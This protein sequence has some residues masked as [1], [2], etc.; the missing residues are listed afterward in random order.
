[1]AEFHI[2][3]KIRH[4]YQL[5]DA[6]FQT[7]GNILLANFRVSR[8][9]AQN[10]NTQND[11][12]FPKDGVR[13]GD[14]HAMGLIDEIFHFV[15]TLYK[16][17][18]NPDFFRELLDQLDTN[19]TQKTVD[20]L[21]TTFIAEF[22][23]SSV[24]RDQMTAQDYL[25]ASENGIPNREIALEELML[26]WLAN[27][28]PAYQPL[29][30]LF[31]DQELQKLPGYNLVTHYLE[32]YS[33]KQPRFGPRNTDLVY[34]LRSPALMVP[35]SIHG[36]LEYIRT[37]W[38]YLLSDFLLRILSS[39]DFL[40]EEEKLSFMGPGPV[41]IPLYDQSQAGL[42]EGE[43]YSRD[44]DWMPNLVLIAKNSFVWLHQ[45]AIKYKKPVRF[46][47][48]IPDEE[49]Q[50][51][52]QRGINGLWLIGLWERSRASA[53][54]KQ[55]CGNPEAISSAYALHDY[56]IAGDL[57]GEQA[58]EDLDRR[59]RRFGI[60]LASDMVP[61]HM[62][63]DSNWVMDHPDWFI[64]LPY[65]PFP[66]YRFSGP[67]LSDRADVGIFIDD[68][69]YDHSDAAVVF[70]RVDRRSGAEQYI[71]H[72]N[73]GTSFPWNDTAQLDYL[74][75]E[76]REAVIQTIIQVAKRFHI[77]RFDAAMTLT[78]KHFHRLW[79]PQPGSGGDIPSRAE[80][81][82]TDE[83]FSHIMPNEFWREVVDR[84]AV[85]APDTLLLAEA[86]WMM[87]SYFVRT[88]GMHRVYNSAFMILL[89][90]E[91]NAKY[92]S[93]IKN[94]LEFDPEILKRYV[95]FLNNPDERTA[96][97]QFGNG[98]KYFGVCTLMVT[99]PG[100]PMFGHGQIEGFTEKYGMEYRRSYQ[101]EI[102]DAN[103][104]QRH[105]QQVF[106]LMRKRH[107]F[108]NVNQFLLYDFFTP[109]GGVDENVFAY[110]NRSDQESTL[111]IYNNRYESTRG[112]IR[113]SAAFIDKASE[114]NQ[115]IQKSLH[116]GL[117]IQADSNT[118][119]IFMDQSCGL[120][121]IRKNSD[122]ISNGLYFEL[123]GYQT[124][125]FLNFRQIMDH[126]GSWQRLHN[127]LD[128]RGTIS[129]DDAF[130][131]LRMQPVLDPMRQIFT[132]EYY[133]A[134]LGPLL[135]PDK[136]FMNANLLN[137]TK[138][139]LV[140]L[141]NGF[142]HW[143]GHSSAEDQ[144]IEHKLAEFSAAF[145]MLHLKNHLPART[146]RTLNPVI[147]F[148]DNLF[149]LGDPDNQVL[150]F[151]WFFLHNLGNIESKDH[152]DI[153]LENWFN[154][155]RLGKLLGEFLQDTGKTKDDKV[156]ET[157]AWLRWLISR[158][159]FPDELDLENSS[160]WLR[161]RFSQPQAGRLLNINCFEKVE[162][163][164]KEGFE[165][166]CD[167]IEVFK[168]MEILADPTQSR[169]YS[170][171]RLLRVHALMSSYKQTASLAEYQVEKF[172][173]LLANSPA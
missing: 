173:N 133:R 3:R 17:Q 98:D 131:D 113:T 89:R 139:K 143:L 2:S 42:L 54:I 65:S 79:F 39:L 138:Q 100:L 11:P 101:D 40:K 167:W 38:G 119:T 169:S 82:L 27:Q 9:F 109:Q 134:I 25:L 135:L 1:M 104:I 151:S 12:A 103:F 53:R 114:N 150:L 163:F 21:L 19:F 50:I 77:I 108:A 68:H 126:D 28:N 37:E 95:N 43:R 171:E 72:G 51:L 96:I 30:S 124:H 132:K 13:P 87:E 123:N 121:Y 76:V 75:P 56:Q 84:V 162:Y 154:E 62:A 164:S 63:I 130:F 23:S 34:L 18:K 64:S 91:E 47:S 67:D 78:R 83:E 94:T 110:S 61:N 41:E 32:N 57:G 116:E 142:T 33:K 73:D 4:R 20:Q 136:P 115:L 93:L 81:A 60:R 159:N 26:I 146:A 15:I 160:D 125:V 88:L 117:A 46:L 172:F 153:V 14:I 45:L 161:S 149:T 165:K 52:A 49:L 90:D 129:M 140:N 55:L 71:Y 97:D 6:L 170:A 24:F 120:E 35:N 127:F 70:K 10:I 92:R 16:K 48:D 59:A 107:L 69:Y 148:I 168:I 106:P 147:R 44:S 99:L 85:E 31:E 137:E 144:F 36:Q 155:L 152:P 145:Q 7:D 74:K 166:Y 111:V 8:E 118:F 66:A 158:H 128:G 86:F 156:D 22:P 29:H 112:W 157:I 80:H 105:E 102:P 58:F 5:D 141:L 122:I